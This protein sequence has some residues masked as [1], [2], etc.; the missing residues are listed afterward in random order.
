M[1]LPSRHREKETMNTKSVLRDSNNKHGINN[2]AHKKLKNTKFR[3][4]VFTM[5]SEYS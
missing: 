2:L 1:L 4:G 5:D 3:F